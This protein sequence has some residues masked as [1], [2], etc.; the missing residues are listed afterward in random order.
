[1]ATEYKRDGRRVI[2]PKIADWKLKQRERSLFEGAEVIPNWRLAD[3]SRR[4]LAD[5]TSHL[6]PEIPSQVGKSLKDFDRTAARQF[7]VVSASG[8]A[9]RSA[10]SG[11]VLIASGYVIESAGPF[12]RILESKLHAQA[13]NDDQSGEYALRFLQGRGTGISKLA[14]RY[15]KKEEVELLSTFAHADA[16]GLRLLEVGARRG[17][18]EVS[19]TE[20]NVLPAADPE[21]AASVLYLISYETV[22]IATLVAEV[23]GVGLEIPPWI[24]R[25]L[26]R[27]KE[28]SEALARSSA[29]SA[30]R[31]K[32]RKEAPGK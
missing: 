25:E 20:I 16:S 19:E 21:K 30:G 10:G 13:I 18:S 27:L 17:N 26:Q 2:Q 24:S 9:V 14:Q 8:I 11:L 7:A 12:R 28:A 31:K 5:T 32:R 23:F 6:S 22:G 15:G 3:K 29:P 1:M 4:F